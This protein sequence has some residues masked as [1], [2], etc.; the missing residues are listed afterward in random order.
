MAAQRGAASISIATP[1]FFSPMVGFGTSLWHNTTNRFDI[2][3]DNGNL[4]K[5]DLDLLHNFLATNGP[6]PVPTSGPPGPPF[7]DV[8]GDGYVDML[9]EALFRGSRRTMPPSA[10]IGS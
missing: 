4:V 3:G 5:P 10:S 1:N 7:Y 6:T 9:D 2:N 8:S